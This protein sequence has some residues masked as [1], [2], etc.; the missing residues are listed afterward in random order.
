MSIKTAKTPIRQKDEAFDVKMPPEKEWV[1]YAITYFVRGGDF[2]HCAHRLA[3]PANWDGVMHRKC[4]KEE[5][6]EVLEV[7]GQMDKK[8]GVIK[9]PS[10]VVN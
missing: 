7:K 5:E 9:T 1:M 3:D 2:E 6:E 10:G 8:M 4:T